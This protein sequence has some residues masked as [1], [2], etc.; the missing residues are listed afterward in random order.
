LE[1]QIS[2]SLRNDLQP[3]TP[4]APTAPVQ[5]QDLAPPS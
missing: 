5:S 2:H 1:F 4:T 3:S